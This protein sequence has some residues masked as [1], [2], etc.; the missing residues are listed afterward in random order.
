MPEGWGAQNFALIFACRPSGTFTRQHEFKNTTNFHETTFPVR[1]KRKT[2]RPPE[3]E[4]KN[5]NWVRERG[6]SA[7][8]GAVRRRVVRWLGPTRSGPKS[9]GPNSV[10]AQV[11]PA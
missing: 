11:G 6:K 10:W 8:F 7:N 3:R 9:V 4:E 5:D 2:R 1:D